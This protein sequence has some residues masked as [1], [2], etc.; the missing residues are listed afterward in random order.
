MRITRMEAAQCAVSILAAFAFD[1]WQANRTEPLTGHAWLLVV[2]LVGFATA[3]LATSIIF[4]LEPR[5]LAARSLL[6][7]LDRPFVAGRQ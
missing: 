3:R 4:R 7:W 5:C 6:Q 2:L 1:C